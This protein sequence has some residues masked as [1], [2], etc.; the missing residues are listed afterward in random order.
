MARRISPTGRVL[1]GLYSHGAFDTWIAR[2]ATIF[3]CAILAWGL[4]GAAEE[5]VVLSFANG[6]C[7]E[8][9]TPAPVF[10]G[11]APV[12]APL[13]DGEGNAHVAG[14]QLKRTIQREPG[15]YR[16]QLTVTNQRA[17]PIELSRLVILEARG[18]DAVQVA[19]KGVAAWTVFR[20][21]R[22]K[23][24]IPGPFRPTV[25]NEASRDAATDNAK[26]VVGGKHTDD[27]NEVRTM[28][29]ARFHADPALVIMPDGFPDADLFLGFDGQTKHLSDL[30][31]AMDR[32]GSALESI[33]VSAEFDNVVVGP[34]ESRE[35]HGLHLQTGKPCA[36]LLAD[37]V[38]RIHAAY[39]G[40]HSPLRNVFCTWYFYGPEILADDL[41]R[42]LQTLR[43]RPVD[44]DTFLIDYNWDDCFGDWNA[45]PARFPDGMKEMADEI[46]AAGLAPGIWTCPFI[47]ESNADVLKRYPDLP[48]CNRAGERLVFKTD[49]GH[50]YVLDPTAPS[51]EK[52]LTELCQ[53]LTGWGYQYLKFDFL[54]AVVIYEDAVFY[55]RSMNRAQAYRRGLELLRKAAGEQTV[56]GVWGGLFEANAGLVDINRSGSDVRG[57]W[58]PLEGDAHATRYVLRMRQTFARAF[59]DEKL[60]TSDQDAL[61][62]RRRTTPWR[63]TKPHLS[64]GVFTDE[65]AF[66]TV[67]YR[68]LG[69]GVVQVSDKLDEVP[70]DRYALYHATLPTFA[71]VAKRFYAWDDY[72]PEYFSSAFPARA[73]LSPWVMVSLCNWNGAEAKK[74]GFA[75]GD[76]PDLPAGERFAAFEFKT[77][78]FLGVFDRRDRINLDLPAHGAR[79]I[80]LTPLV[81]GG[82]T[83]IGGDLNLAC[84]AEIESIGPSSV[85][86]RPDLRKYAAHYTLLDW[87]D[88][89][90]T[91]QRVTVGEGAVVLREGSL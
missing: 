72:L 54:R 85:V 78:T 82:P 20:L 3:C 57:H 62:L 60:W 12:P 24:D 49:M 48:L 10:H 64:M 77:Q 88:G 52:F 26:A 53:K 43:A 51:A 46:K 42:D 71:P 18:R 59:Y 75:L 86:L 35:T 76:V 41:R 79:V 61:Q 19:G 67:V 9:V 63:K 31:L 58:D 90:G 74:L 22:H 45:D 5:A 11:E 65:E 16:L 36:A 13:F 81:S 87:H 7:I 29:S 44:F 39:G 80:R 23:N 38:E 14:L 47:I 83:L 89:R 37:H 15:G 1:T 70:P 4:A 17:Q 21:A 68:F 40:R 2:R 33:M 73:G 30:E 55:D 28:A 91:L 66:S 32:S 56:I 6:T 84:G 25:W 8:F 27:P 69:G 34:G 50:C